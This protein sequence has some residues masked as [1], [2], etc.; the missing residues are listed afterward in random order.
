MKYVNITNA[1]II[2]SMNNDTKHN[3]ANY[4]IANKVEPEEILEPIKNIANGVIN[5]SIKMC[6]EYFKTPAG[7]EYLQMREKI[8]KIGGNQWK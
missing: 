3:F 7:K 5:L 1:D 8:E 6:N 4:C 2:R